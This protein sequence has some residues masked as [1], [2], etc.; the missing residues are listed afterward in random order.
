MA[1]NERNLGKFLDVDPAKLLSDT[2]VGSY[3]YIHPTV[4][5][6]KNVCIG[7]HCHIGE[8]VEIAD[9][10]E[11]ANCVNIGQEVK[12]GFSECELGV[13]KTTIG[14]GSIIEPNADVRAGANLGS[15][16]VVMKDIIVGECA[17][18]SQTAFVSKYVLP[19]S[20][21]CNGLAF[22]INS[23]AINGL[24]S[25]KNISDMKDFIDD[26]NKDISTFSKAKGME[27]IVDHGKKQIKYASNFYYGQI[28]AYVSQFAIDCASK[29]QLIPYNWDEAT[30]Q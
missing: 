15:G 20:I 22:G 9:N 26:I 23:K 28:K 2:K 12:I 19:F 21:V 25:L 14:V 5:I 3:T 13:L 7:T 24:E 29:N 27:S 1:E 17:I 6:G 11:I 18:V 30:K 4:K 16:C 10:V 8:Y